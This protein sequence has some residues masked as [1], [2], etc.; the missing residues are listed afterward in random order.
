LF[1]SKKK[2]SIFE[3]QGKYREQIDY[4][5]KPEK[6]MKILV[7]KFSGNFGKRKQGSIV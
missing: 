4:L 7:E 6:I 5:P 1:N 2:E 3:E